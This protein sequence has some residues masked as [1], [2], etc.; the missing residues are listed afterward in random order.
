STCIPRCG[1]GMVLGN[2][3]CDDG[4]REGGDGC[5]IACLTEAFFDCP[6]AGGECTEILTCGNGSIEGFEECDDA[7]TDNGDG[8]SSDCMWDPN[9]DCSIVG[10]SCVALVTCGNG[11]LEGVEPCDDGNTED[12]DGCSADCSQVEEG[13]IC[14]RPNELCI[15]EPRCGDGNITLG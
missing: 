3:E 9:Y 12:D 10:E 15:L 5:N 4:N 1:D 6:P 11:L 13:Y 8:C 14:L 2:E 7:N